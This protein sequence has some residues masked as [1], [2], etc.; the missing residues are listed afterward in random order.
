MDPATVPADAQTASERPVGGATTSTPGRA[1]ATLR[2]DGPA[3]DG[4]TVPVAVRAAGLLL[5]VVGVVNAGTGVAAL[6]L[7]QQDVSTVLAIGLVAAGVA[8]VVLA[9]LVW[10]A[11]RRAVTVALVLFELLLLPRLLTLGDATAPQRVST[12]VLALV[13]V[14]LALAFRALRRT[15]RSAS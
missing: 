7:D 5:A 2:G 15:R 11:R 8:T 4:A 1:A 12:A 3:D 9:R 14:V 10:Q 6:V 13:V